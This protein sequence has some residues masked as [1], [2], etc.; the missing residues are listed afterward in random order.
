MVKNAHLDAVIN[1]VI[2]LALCK[3]LKDNSKNFWNNIIIKSWWSEVVTISQNEIL[4]VPEK[5]A[6]VQQQMET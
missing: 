5:E 2:I 3:N 4:S 6:R 1:N